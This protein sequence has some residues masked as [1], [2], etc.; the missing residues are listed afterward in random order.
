MFKMLPAFVAL[1]VLPLVSCGLVTTQ[2]VY[3]GLR[4]QQRIKDAGSHAA[5]DALGSYDAYQKEREKVKSAPE[6][7]EKPSL[8]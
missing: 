1:L 5:P 8:D 2:S 4:S 7:T 6:A 3:E